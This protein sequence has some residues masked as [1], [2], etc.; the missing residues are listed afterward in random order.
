MASLGLAEAQI[1]K[2]FL[3]ATIEGEGFLIREPWTM[4]I[5]GL[6]SNS[7]LHSPL[8][9]CNVSLFHLL[10]MADSG[11]VYM[12]GETSHHDMFSMPCWL[13]PQSVVPNVT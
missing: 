2:F 13:R 4:K 12:E 3:I 5:P 1:K 7:A 11:A 8:Q 6:S 9:K 10:T